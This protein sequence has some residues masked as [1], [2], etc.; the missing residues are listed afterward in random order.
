MEKLELEAT[1]E[2]LDEVLAFVDGYLENVDCPM[3][4]QL[5]V[6]VAV[7]ETF[8]NIVHYAYAPG[9]GPATILL[10]IGQDPLSIT[11]VFMDKG[12]PFDPL[13][14]EDP[15]VTLS[16]EERKIGGLG[17]FLVKKNMDE[18]HYE[19]KDGYNILTISKAL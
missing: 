1:L 10:N 3:K 8:V 16:L 13:A 6:D 4:S 11:L 18:I 2:N 12:V 15:D 19:Y 17:I 14:H 7:E 9:T 5:Q